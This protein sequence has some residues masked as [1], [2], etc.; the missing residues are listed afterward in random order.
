MDNIY[1]GDSIFVDNRKNRRIFRL[2]NIIWRYQ[3]FVLEIQT[4]DFIRYYFCY[5]HLSAISN[6]TNIL[7]FFIHSH[8][9]S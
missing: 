9:V 4:R 5:N 2:D 7:Q 8:E 6:F 3:Y 1:V